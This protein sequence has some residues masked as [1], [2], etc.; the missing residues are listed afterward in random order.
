MGFLTKIL[1]ARS[2]W[3]WL[4]ARS[5]MSAGDDLNASKLLERTSLP[6]GPRQ[7]V[8]AQLGSCYSR[9]GRSQSAGVAYRKAI[10]A[11]L[12]WGRRRDREVSNYIVDYANFFLAM[13]FDHRFPAEKVDDM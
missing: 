13:G 3:Y 10:S 5:L 11:E 2:Y 12:E 7:I 4:S 6:D 8:L 1:H 9:M